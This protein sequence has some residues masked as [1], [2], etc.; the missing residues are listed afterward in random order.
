VV[1]EDDDETQVLLVH[2]PR[3]DDWSF[4]KGKALDGESDEDC[5]LREVREEAGLECELGRELPTVSYTSKGRPK[6]VRYWLMQPVAGE[7]APDREVDEIVWLGLS[8]A[9]ERLTYG[10]DRSLLES[11]ERLV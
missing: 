10:H 9:G 4:P 7:F 5:A 8:K 3:Y 1:Q 6:R 11:V 2:R